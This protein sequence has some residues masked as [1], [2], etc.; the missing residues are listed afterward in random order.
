MI[1]VDFKALD[2]NHVRPLGVYGSQSQ[3]VEFLV[4]INA[5]DSGM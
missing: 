3:I 5:V 1:K 4:G 2:H